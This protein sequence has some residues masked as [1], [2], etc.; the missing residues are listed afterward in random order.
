M[1]MKTF[2]SG[3]QSAYLSMQRKMSSVNRLVAINKAARQDSVRTDDARGEKGIQLVD[4]QKI[5]ESSG[6]GTPNKKSRS[7]L[8][9]EID[10]TSEFEKAT[11]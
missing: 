4:L 2:A 11:R 5:A 3:S 6:G 1:K 10:K 7:I 9:K 8:D